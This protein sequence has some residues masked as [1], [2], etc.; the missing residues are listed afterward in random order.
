MS[1][2]ISYRES[3]PMKV[4]FLDLK[5]TYYEI[6]DRV[7]DE[8]SQFFQSGQF[9]GGERLKNFETNF[10]SF[11]KSSNCVGVANG[12]EALELS[13][14][15]LE[16]GVGDEVIVPSNTFIATWFSVS[17]CGAKP[18]PVEPCWSTYGIKAES[19]KKVINKKTKAIIPVHLYGQ[20]AELKP[21]IDL[22]KEYGLYVIEDAAQAVGARYDSKEIGS[23]G[24]L[25]AWSF[26]PGKNLGAF[27]DAGAVTTN[28]KELAERIRMLANYGSSEKYVHDYI[29]CNSRLDPLQAII[30]NIKLQ[31]IDEWNEKRRKIAFRYL[32]SLRNLDLILPDKFDLDNCSWHLFPIRLEERDEL[33]KYLNKSKVQTLI[34]YPV[35]PHKQLAYKG[36]YEDIDLSITEKLSSHLLS[37]P[38]FPHLEM[39]SVD[40][41][42]DKVTDFFSK[43]RK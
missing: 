35:P 28:N 27:G 12:L 9:I 17:N 18:V 6:Q 7:D 31:Y 39:D 32:E 16:I 38:I 22:A 20:P 34:H 11:V 29:G 1:T 43:V 21:I 10:A 42:I 2:L 37:L 41:V 8:I 5:D 23:H 24:D 14:K 36:K 30:L 4:P 40:Y 13:L 19:I 15:A 33:Q 3:S 25:V 26:Y